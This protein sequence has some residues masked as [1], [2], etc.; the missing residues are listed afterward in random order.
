MSA[1]SAS[2]KVKG[3]GHRQRNED[4]TDR[5]EGRGGQFETIQQE[6]VSGPAKCKSLRVTLPAASYSIFLRSGRRM[7]YFSDER[8]LRGP[9]GPHTGQ[10]PRFRRC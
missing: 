4:D 7:D 5:Y 8:A 6:Q 9:G 2:I 10:V 1:S 3:R